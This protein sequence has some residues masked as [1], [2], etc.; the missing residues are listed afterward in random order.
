LIGAVY[1]DSGF[2]IVEDFIIRFWND[3]IKKTVKIKIDPKTKLQEYSLKYF[4]KL[5]IYKVLSYRG[6]QHSPSYKISIKIHD[7]KSF[8]GIANSKNAAEHNAAS[9]IIKDLKTK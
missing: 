9:N 4:K 2:K 7:S 3:D 5:P 8:Y 6:P 1:L